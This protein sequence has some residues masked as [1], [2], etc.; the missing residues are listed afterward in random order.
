LLG[1]SYAYAID[2]GKGRIAVYSLASGQLETIGFP[3]VNISSGFSV[4]LDDHLWMAGGN[5]SNVL[6]LDPAT[7]HVSAVDFRTSGISALFADSAGR[8]W[9]ADDA[10]GGIGYY[11]Q[12]KQVLV[13][14][15]SSKHSSVTTLAMDRDGTLWAGTAS[16]DLLTVRLGVASVAGSA[17]GSVAGLVRDPSGVVWS[18]ASG[19]GTLVYRALTGGG[20]AHVA[21]TTASSLAFDGRDRAWLG[22]SESAAFHIVLN[23]DR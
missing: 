22:D 11:D 9:Y 23:G 5:S 13:T 3:F 6:S 18:Y 15:P 4:G 19:P 20:A 12:S 7:K 1:T 16:G 10:T 8:V 21:A 14:I 2:Q 17:G